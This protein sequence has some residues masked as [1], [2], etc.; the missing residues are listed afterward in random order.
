VWYDNLGRELLRSGE[1]K[2]MIENDGVTGVTSNPTIFE[3]AIGGERTYDNDLHYLVDTGLNVQGIYEGL[4]VEDIRE[5]ADLLAPI[6]QKTSGLDGYVS[7]EVSPE[8]AYEKS[9]TIA[10]AKRLFDL[11]NRENLMI[12]AP[13]TTQGLEATHE[14]IAAGVNVNVTLIFSLE[15][16]RGA[17]M[18]YVTGM[19]RRLAE[20]GDPGVASVASF[21]VS[22]VDT[23]IDE[24]LK[25]IADPE[26]RPAALELLGKAATANAKLAYQIYRDIFHGDIFKELRQQ[27]VRPQRIVWA[28]TSTKNPE[29]P[30]TMYVDNLLGPETVNTM[31]AVTLSA[32]RDHGNPRVLLLEGLDEAAAVFPR[33]EELGIDVP[34]IMDRLLEDGVKSFAESFEMLLE[35]IAKKRTRLL[36]G[37]GHRSASLGDLQPSVDEALARLDKERLAESVWNAN[38]SIWSDDP[39][40]RIS[41]S[42]RLGWLQV[43]ETMG[44][45]E[46]RIKEFAD[47]IRSSGFTNVVLLGM[48]GS[49]LAAEVFVH[50]FERAEGYLDLKVLDTT[51]PAS[52]L[53]VERSLDLK[54]TLF[55]VAS[56]SGGT[57][58]VLSLYKYFHSRVESELGDKAGAHF[59]AIT[60]PGTSLGKLASE[61]GFRRIF[62]NPADI[63]G[64][65]SALSYFGLVPA[66]L[67]GVDVGR[68]LMRAAQAVEASTPDVPALENPGIWMGAI[69]SLGAL[70]ARDKL[71][72][73]ISPPLARFELWLEQLVAESLGK[74]GKG[75]LPVVGE[76]PG[77]P[78]VYGND[79]LFVYLR[80]DGDGTYDQAV[81]ALEQAGHPVVTQRLH[82]AYD[83]GREIFR[84]EFATA[85]AGALFHINPFDQPNVQESKD[86]T[87]EI[88]A[89]NRK[90]SAM[91]EVESLSVSDPGLTAGLSEFFGTPP[92]GSYVA[93]NVFLKP[94]R[95]HTEILQ[96]M[97]M[98]FRDKLKMATAL[99][100]GPRYLHST[101]QMHKGG[102]ATGYFVEITGDDPE[103]A[104]IPGE[105]YTFSK[106]K[107]AQ[108]LGDYHALK[109]KGRKIIHVHLQ[110]DGD[111]SKLR[112]ALD[113]ALNS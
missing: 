78:E 80:L 15:Q 43:V 12:K 68:L 85:V 14:L 91:N 52:I 64:R 101:G 24:R 53:E 63:G 38:V 19:E 93:F 106:L 13:A 84:W 10:E 99:G 34:Q 107:T 56:K 100:F 58:E 40:S 16:Y 74:E 48:G 29:Y 54:R 50:C 77:S 27:G 86:I 17:A 96:Q 7:L 1:L 92:P 42:Q 71:T 73:V 79:R 95:E 26:S 75:I 59:I 8:L 72:F 61:S 20:G 111:L 62:L 89:A 67:I 98:A 69:C 109:N 57:I 36:R 28:S 35:G 65:F 105:H 45:E 32:Y 9:A 39:Q 60:D 88:L 46:R 23:V 25:E 4:V 112:D 97:R 2:K 3:K 31:P 30:D 70:N 11:V 87:K 83:L 44:G 76:P 33:L 66:A 102:P 81:S 104:P 22:R 47:E 49:S 41:I 6:Y 37:W 103:D 110:A 18:A 55:I 51:V 82:T 94:S 113:R 108:A 5:A 21:F 90:D